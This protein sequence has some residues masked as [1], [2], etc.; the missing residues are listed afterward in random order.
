MVR[1]YSK[2][3]GAEQRDAGAPNDDLHQEEGWWK[4]QREHTLGASPPVDRAL[5]HPGAS[6][7]VEEDG[8]SGGVDGEEGDYYVTED[9]GEEDP[10][11]QAGA[12][13][14]SHNP[15]DA[16]DLSETKA[17]RLPTRKR[18]ANSVR[19]KIQS[20]TLRALFYTL[21]RSPFLDLLAYVTG[22][23]PDPE[24]MIEFADKTPH[25]WANMV[26][27][28][29]RLGGYTEKTESV[30]TNILVEMGKLSDVELMKMMRDLDEQVRPM[31]EHNPSAPDEVGSK[32]SVPS[33]I[34]EVDHA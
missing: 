34:D 8:P 30:N 16:L 15:F 4:G 32:P 18:I 22:C 3:D 5:D 6:S 24:A 13:T 19:P 31:I 11:A 2:E 1:E 12:V 33:N 27:T 25:L 10:P 29:A 7:D 9:E 20:D 23:S 21:D 28:F 17:Q 26:G 14:S